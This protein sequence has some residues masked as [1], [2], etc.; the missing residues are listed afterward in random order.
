MKNDNPNLPFNII[1]ESKV[2]EESDFQSLVSLSDELKE[3]FLKSQVFR[4]RTEAEISVLNNIKHP[5]PSSKYWQATR[6][7]GV[8]FHEL[9]MLSYEYRKNLVEIKKLERDLNMEADDLDR[10]LKQ[11]EVERKLFI[12]K[13]MERT[14]R[15]R[16]REI[17]M[18]SEIKEREANMMTPDELADVDNHQLVSYTQRFIKQAKAMGENGSPAERQNLFG[19]L[20][21]ALDACDKNGILENVLAPFDEDT[22]RKLGSPSERKL[23]M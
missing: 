14:A 15:D 12:S 4:T 20:F 23:L 19:Q 5:T 9:V 10:E 7:Q 21:S 18:W 17:H 22:K 3:T 13:N 6:E 8:M 2:L 16:I 11:I 1:Q